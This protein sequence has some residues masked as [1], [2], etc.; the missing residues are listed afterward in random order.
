[1]GAQVYVMDD[2][3]GP[4]TQSRI[5]LF[6]THKEAVDL[7]KKD[8][9]LDILRTLTQLDDFRREAR[10]R[11]LEDVSLARAILYIAK[12]VP[13]FAH[14]RKRPHLINALQA[15]LIAHE[16]RRSCD[17]IRNILHNTL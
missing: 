2:L 1:M 4:N 16:A 6:S 9:R 14:N 17:V 7:I 8:A 12:S 13:A 15:V 5:V 3:R 10:I 11:L